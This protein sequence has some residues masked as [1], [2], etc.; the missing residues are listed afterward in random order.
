V[1]LL[2]RLRP[3]VITLGEALGFLRALAQVEMDSF[4]SVVDDQYMWMTN[5][6]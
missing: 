1:S 6:G 3:P 4:L 5:R 2:K